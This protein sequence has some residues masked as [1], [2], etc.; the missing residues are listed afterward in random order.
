MAAPF[1]KKLNHF[2]ALESTDEYV[3]ALRRSLAAEKVQK[4]QV[5]Q[6]EEPNRTDAGNLPAEKA[7]KIR[8]QIHPVPESEVLRVVKGGSKEQG[9]WM[10]PWL[11]VEFARWL[12]PAFAVWCN[13][14]IYG[15]LVAKA[16][17]APSAGV[18]HL[19]ELDITARY[20]RLLNEAL[21][22]HV[23]KAEGCT[24]KADTV[25]GTASD[26]ARFLCKH[27]K[28]EF[29]AE[30]VGRALQAHL[31]PD[32]ATFRREARIRTYTLRRPRTSLALA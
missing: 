26:F 2:L 10:H 25:R 3:L 13:Q 18:S 19:I 23:F 9:T 8:K 17:P 6:N 30:W 32:V 4:S 14:T 21:W 24:L 5:P 28:A 31:N 11:A 1:G 27:Y 29:H 15:L 7:P 16:M 12:S 22:G 20:W